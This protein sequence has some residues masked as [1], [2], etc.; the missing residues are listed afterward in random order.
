MILFFTSLPHT[1]LS[2]SMACSSNLNL[3][4]MEIIRLVCSVFLF[5]APNPNSTADPADNTS[6]YILLFYHTSNCRNWQAMWNIGLY[7]WWMYS[8]L[9]G[10]LPNDTS[11]QHYFVLDSESFCY[12]V[13]CLLSA[14]K[15]IWLLIA[16]YQVTAPFYIQRPLSKHFRNHQSTL[17]IHFTYI[18]F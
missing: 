11:C 8:P 17:S 4:T 10:C 1:W 6:I 18:S 16:D 7:I 14:S 3:K 12:G 15:W 2:L 9:I 13:L 5:C